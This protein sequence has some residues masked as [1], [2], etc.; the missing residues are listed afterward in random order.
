VVQF[1]L[2]ENPG[3]H[4]ILQRARHELD[5]YLVELQHEDVTPWQYVVY[6]DSSENTHYS[7]AKVGGRLAASHNRSESRV[8]SADKKEDKDVFW[9]SFVSVCC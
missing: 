7:S 2:P 1:M 5:F 8:Q 3:T 4:E 6:Q 9:L